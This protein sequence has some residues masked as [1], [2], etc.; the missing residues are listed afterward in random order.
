MFTNK[1]IFFL[2]IVFFSYKLLSNDTYKIT[3]MGKFDG[4]TLQLPN[5]GKFNVFKADAAFSDTDGNF[6]DAIG[7]GVRETD[8]NNTIINLYVVLIFKSSDGSTMLT[9]PTRTES[10]IQAGTGSFVILHATGVFEKYLQ[11]K[12]KYA[13]S[14]SNTGAFI[15]ENIC[16]NIN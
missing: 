6:G 11:Y 4:E 14:T 10:D 7:R 1:I 15:Q 9:R 5:E 12:C 3:I 13:I 2:L 8:K 16:K